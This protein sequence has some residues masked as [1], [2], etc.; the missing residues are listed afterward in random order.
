MATINGQEPAIFVYNL[1]NSYDSK[2]SST[3]NSSSLRLPTQL[4]EIWNNY[5]SIPLTVPT[6][7]T[8]DGQSIGVVTY[9]LNNLLSPAVNSPNNIPTYATSQVISQVIPPNFGNN[10]NPD[11]VGGSYAPTLTDG[12]GK[13]IPYNPNVYILDGINH[14]L[15]FPSGLPVGINPNGM[16]ITYYSYNSTTGGGSGSSNVWQAT[17][18]PT[19]TQ[20][21]VR[22]N[23]AFPVNPSSNLLGGFQS[24][25]V[26]GAGVF[27]ISNTTSAD[28]GSFRAGV[29]SGSQ[30][31]QSNRGAAST[32][33]GLNNMASGNYSS[34]LAG[35]GNTVSGLNSSITSGIGLNN[36]LANTMLTSNLQ[37]VGSDMESLDCCN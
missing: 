30:W 25:E 36:T 13:I 11:G 8:T 15:S 1:T 4:N 17:T 32:A 7:F 2:V 35:Q 21:L 18:D 19:T 10:S 9:H 23:L 27:S 5:S 24:T 33:F 20:N 34:V 6:G 16:S 29:V 31:Q 28:Q 26:S 3:N 37:F 14:L 12:S 22:Y